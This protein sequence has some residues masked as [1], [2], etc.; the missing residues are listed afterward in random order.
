M[1]FVSLSWLG[2]HVQIP[3][4]ATIEDLAADLVRVGIEEEE[5]LPAA[6]TGP[7]VAGRVLSIDTQ[8]QSNGK[9]INYCRVDVG[10]YNDA[11]GTGAEPSDQASRGIICGAHNFAVGDTVVVALPGAVLPGPFAI[12]ARKTYGHV[13]DGMICS[14]RELGLGDDHDGIIV[15][16][17]RM[18]ADELP[19]PGTDLIPVLGLGEEVLEV[20]VTPDRGYCFA[21]RGLAR[22]Y[23][24][25]T[26][27]PFTDP[28]LPEALKSALPT[29]DEGAFPIQVAAESERE[30]RPAANRFVTRVVRDI[31]PAATTPDWMKK[32]LEQAGM[33]PLGLSI[34][35]TNYVMLDLGQPLHAYDIRAVAAPF[36][37]RRAKQGEAFETLDGSNRVLDEE[38][39]VISDS[40]E[41]QL[42]SRIV[43]LA[44]VM[45]GLNSEVQ[46]D[47]TDVVIEAAHFDNVSVA[48]T[49]RRHKLY[50]ESSKRF[51]R[52]VDPELAPVAA[53][54]VAELL[55]EY[56]GGVIEDTG[57]D[58][59]D[60]PAP[61]VIRMKTSEPER[62]TGVE[63]SAS[64]VIKY[65]EEIG[66]HVD[67]EE[68]VLL[69]TPPTWRPDLVGPAHLVEEVAR[70]DGY[71][72][73]PTRVATGPGSQGLSQAQQLRRHVAER[74]S[75][76]GLVE[77]K[78]YPFIG[79]AHDR[80]SIPH[81]DSR[82]SAVRL[83][84][85]LAE[86]APLLRTSLLDSMLETAER[87]ASRG[88]SPIA[89]FEL[90]QVT[91]P[92]GTVPAAIIGVQER[93]TDEEL[94]TLLA[95]VP[96][97]PWH[98]AGIM[99]GRFAPL[100]GEELLQGINTH[101]QWGWSDAIQAA[102]EVGALD[103]VRIEATRTWVPEG[104]AKLRG[105]P[106]P[107]S[108]ATPEEAA[109]FHPGRCATL[110]VRIGRGLRVVGRAGELHPRIIEEYGLPARSNAFEIDLDA[111]ASQVKP[112]F[113]Q[114][115]PVSTYPPVKEDLAVVV[116][117]Y[118]SESAVAQVIKRGAGPLLEDL[119]LFDIYRGSQI[120]EGSRSL[121]YS[122]TL[123]APD[124]TL[125]PEEV[126]GVR[127][128]IIT[129]LEK[130]LK[131]TIR[132]A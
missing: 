131:A 130:R 115:K 11:P 69:V 110:F 15:L 101:E 8:R 43:G 58:F 85:P 108:V 57:F 21:M 30:G 7:L 49:S 29:S 61:E 23:S 10:Q 114:V 128:K 41:G 31:D 70:L 75:N 103:G 99:G 52:G 78:S 55:A 123:R 127:R 37:V 71:D 53:A 81:T 86:D 33:R 17:D 91:Q 88:V 112:G 45:G 59:N 42:G 2:D 111:V 19:E 51:E 1:P 39:I 9:D 62:L 94:A 34:D 4:D 87:N 5:I 113:L 74:L 14:D 68:D 64:Q 120:P 83:R 96:A 129:D 25:S 109:P 102:I 117:D 132:T 36:V 107:E 63:Y 32:R 40:P 97:Q 13:S 98:V 84:N 28:G 116:E 73:I 38:D 89:L 105:A 67:V 65:L 54:R 46:D 126:T 12:S 82:R 47:T 60:V 6:V 122:L 121:A 72:N 76:A 24:H 124:R 118:I 66:C 20:N 80:Q 77:V 100:S 106:L 35:V 95:G 104:T 18:P 3:E 92:E 56:G 119:S 90:G 27:A 22:E 44:G 79:D 125:T 93:P 16:N 26:G 48:R 50:T